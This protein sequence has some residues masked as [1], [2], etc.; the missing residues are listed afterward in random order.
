[1]WLLLIWLFVPTWFWL[2][3]NLSLLVLKSVH[4]INN[5]YDLTFW[6][7]LN[8]VKWAILNS[9]PHTNSFTVILIFFC[10]YIKCIL[11]PLHLSV[12]IIILYLEPVSPHVGL[13]RMHFLRGIHTFWTFVSTHAQC[14]LS[15]STCRYTFPT[16]EN[17]RRSLLEI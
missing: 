11:V 5:L 7:F 13:L 8:S 14:E 10:K 4:F 2:L 15:W 12:F 1:M 3:F 17:I 6:G 9:M 16:E